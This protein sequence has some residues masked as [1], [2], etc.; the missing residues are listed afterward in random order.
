M[1]RL[2]GSG[3]LGKRG[4]EDGGCRDFVEG[5]ILGGAA[6]ALLPVEEE[7]AVAVGEAG[8]GI[9]AE[10]GQGAVDP[11]GWALQ[12]CVVADGGFVEDEVADGAERA[13]RDRAGR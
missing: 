7:A 11:C 5:K 13:R 10:T 3:A 4:Q 1:Y 8:G 9:D 12:F 6:G 2:G